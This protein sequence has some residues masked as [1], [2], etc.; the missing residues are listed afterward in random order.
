[1]IA[2][3]AAREHRKERI[4]ER[5]AILAW[6]AVDVDVVGSQVCCFNI[7]GNWRLL[8]GIDNPYMGIYLLNIIAT[9]LG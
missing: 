4:K 5:K 3:T 9:T 2:L 1:M 8:D 7:A 6:V